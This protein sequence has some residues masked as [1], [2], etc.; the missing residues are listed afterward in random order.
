MSKKLYRA[1]GTNL[2][3]A[4]VDGTHHNNFGSY[5]LAKCVAEG[6]RQ[7]K[8]KLAS[9]IVEDFSGFD[10]ARPDSFEPFRIPASPGPVGVRPLGD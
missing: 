4:F 8:L 2:D 5:Q 6:I 9:E 7:S 10:P 3:K 1:L